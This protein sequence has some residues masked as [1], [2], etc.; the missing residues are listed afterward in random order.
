[1]FVESLH[2]NEM[3]GSAFVA[4]LDY[5]ND[6]RNIFVVF[7]NINIGNK[8][9]NYLFNRKIHV[10]ISEFCLNLIGNFQHFV[11]TQNEIR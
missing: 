5:E 2:V 10:Q 4:T 11:K 6:D 3:R 7:L 1:M 9:W 8:E